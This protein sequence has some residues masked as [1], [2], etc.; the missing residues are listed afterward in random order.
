MKPFL[1][2]IFCWERNSHIS[3][4]SKQCS[5]VAVL[6]WKCIAKLGESQFSSLGRH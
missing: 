3:D 5:F 2:F 6:M 4:I 1:H